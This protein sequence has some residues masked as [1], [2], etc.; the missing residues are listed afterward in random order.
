M[1]STVLHCMRT[2][3][4]T[5]SIASLLSSML[6]VAAQ[7]AP[8]PSV[9]PDLSGVFQSLPAGKIFPGGYTNVG[10]P[11]DVRLLPSPLAPHHD[12]NPQDEDAFK[13]CQAIGPFRMMAIEGL[14]IELVAAPGMIV[15][16][17]EDISHGN[18]RTFYLNRPHP[19]NVKP[20]LQG[21]SIAHWDGDTLIVDTT[22]L[23]DRNWLNDSG[24][25]SS[26]GLHLVERI[27]LLQGGNILEYNLRAEDP[28]VLGKPYTYTRYY[29]R[30][31]AELNEDVCEIDSHWDCGN[32]CLK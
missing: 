17:F 31:D 4:L 6:W 19:Q 7:S 29:G 15:M 11:A 32:L 5:V 21:D 27:R 24:A 23:S 20:T 1:I 13:L 30:L 8:I 12:A 18:L 28:N 26:R 22:G 16:L 3:L 25:H 14:K 10:S 2:S 9:K